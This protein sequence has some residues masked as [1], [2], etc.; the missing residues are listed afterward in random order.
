MK[1]TLKAEEVAAIKLLTQIIKSK[2]VLRGPA[3]QPVGSGYFGP[4]TRSGPD[5]DGETL[6]EWRELKEAAAR[7]ERFLK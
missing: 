7:V 1:T 4:F 5:S 6:V 2:S 3:N